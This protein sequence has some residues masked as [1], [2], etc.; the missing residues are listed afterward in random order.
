MKKESCEEWSPVTVSGFD[1]GYAVSNQGRVYSFKSGRYL[2]PSVSGW[3]YAQVGMTRNKRTFSIQVHRLVAMHF[4]P[5]YAEGEGLEVDHLDGNKAN[6]SASN[7]EWVTPTENRRRAY[8][9]GLTKQCCIRNRQSSI[10]GITESIVRW[11]REQNQN[12]MSFY[13]LGKETGIDRRVIGAICQRQYFAD[14]V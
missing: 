10:A 1:E 12:G 14:V 2:R 6:N 8:F 9:N 5:G 11:L 4:C 7:L 3:G 13:R